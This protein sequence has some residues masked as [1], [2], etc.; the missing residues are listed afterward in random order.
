M[1][2]YDGLF[3]I[4]S[5]L[6]DRGRHIIGELSRD[7]GIFRFAYTPS[8]DDAVQRGFK[9]LP[10]FAK[11]RTAAD[12]YQSTGLFSTFAQRIPSVKRT[13]HAEL[14]SA[15]GVQ[16]ADNPLEVL[17]LSGGI[18]ITDRIE[19]AE[20]RSVDDPLDRPLLFRLAGEVYH[21]AAR[22]IK[23][24]DELTVRPEPSNQYDSCATMIL[25]DSD[26]IIGY[27]PRYYSA[28]VSKLLSTGQKFTAQVIR[29]LIVP[30]DR[31]RWVIKLERTT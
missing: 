6:K 9:L 10:E 12:P 16:N 15:W 5:E 23:V 28:L 1:P 20:A 17:A 4:W 21:P 18:Q 24:G 26:N 13:D 14:L 8:L 29:R 30:E 27:V 19:L 31:G 11:H 2:S 22:D 25:R 7:A 3:V